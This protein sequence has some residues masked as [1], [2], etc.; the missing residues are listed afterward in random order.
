MKEP[1]MTVRK[2]S[3]KYRIYLW[4]KNTQRRCEVRN[5]EFT[6]GGRIP[7]EDIQIALPTFVNGQ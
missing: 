3:K 6:F 2:E 5:L 4:M 7:K 1:D